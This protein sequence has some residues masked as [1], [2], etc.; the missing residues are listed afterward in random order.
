MGMVLAAV[1]G[2]HVALAQ[3]TTGCATRFEYPRN[4]DTATTS[5]RVARNG[6]CTIRANSAN[7]GQQ[8]QEAPR[9]G[10]IAF[11]PGQITY[12]PSPGFVGRDEFT[13]RWLYVT[14]SR[15]GHRYLR[16][17]VEVR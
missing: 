12:T 2:A 1:I 15:T 4:V 16:A 11:A 5:V 13:V 10:S 6:S 9:N 8:V 17:V 14:G 3:P 7:S